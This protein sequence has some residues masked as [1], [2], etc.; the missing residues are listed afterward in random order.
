MKTLLIA[1]FI[2]IT[3][4]CLSGPKL[5]GTGTTSPS[6]QIWTDLLQ[7]HVNKAGEVDYKG[8]IKD[9]AK[10]E[11][12]LDALSS[13]PPDKNTWSEEEQLAYWINAYNAFTVK[14]IADNYPVKSIQDLH[15]TFKIPL[16]NTVWHKKFFKIGGEDASLDQIEHKILRKEFDEPRIHFA[17]NCASIS[18]PPLRN[19]AYEAGKLERQLEEQGRSFINNPKYNK[20]SA[21][22][23][24]ISK[25]FSWFKGDFTKDGSLIEF[26]NRYAK[27]KIKDSAKVNHM[28]YNWDLNE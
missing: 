22:R 23:V 28:D 24:E 6:H 9:K 4:S 16:I 27:V 19:E 2:S 10:L 20:I 7:K 18:C 3:T 21:D 15:P 8:F 5:E 14:L 25:I 1:L 11:K 26:L 17:V 13:T 12:Y